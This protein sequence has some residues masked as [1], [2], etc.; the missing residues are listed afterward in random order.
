[1]VQWYRNRNVSSPILAYQ[2]PKTSGGMDVPTATIHRLL[3]EEHLN[4]RQSVNDIDRIEIMKR[5]R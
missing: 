1:M 4:F 3:H 2:P 5:R